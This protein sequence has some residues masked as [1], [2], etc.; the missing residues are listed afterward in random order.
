MSGEGEDVTKIL[1]FSIPLRSYFHV[2]VKKYWFRLVVLLIL[3][4]LLLYSLAHEKL[5][6][7]L[8]FIVTWL[9]LELAYRQWWLDRVTEKPHFQP[10]LPGNGKHLYI[11]PPRLSAQ[12]RGASV[13]QTAA[14]RAPQRAT[15]FLQPIAERLPGHSTSATELAN[16]AWK[17]A[18]SVRRRWVLRPARSTLKCPSDARGEVCVPTPPPPPTFPLSDRKFFCST[19]LFDPAPFPPNSLFPPG[20]GKGFARIHTCVG[21]QCG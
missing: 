8:L 13:A 2:F 15:P 6:E 11:N 20:I 12:A 16:F 9:Q 7:F 21:R 19:F 18:A 5:F 1:A 10:R 14:F 17:I 3:S 4:V